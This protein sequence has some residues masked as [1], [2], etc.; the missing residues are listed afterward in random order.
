MH[1]GLAIADRDLPDDSGVA[2]A[3][4]VDAA[5][6][7]HS[8]WTNE[9]GGADATVAL[10]AWAAVTDRVLLA[11]GVIPLSARSTATLQL[12]TNRLSRLSHGRLLLGVGVGQRAAAEKL[13]ERPWQ[14]P[15]QWTRDAVGR[16]QGNGAP[17]L[18][19]ALGPR[20]LWLA[21]TA[22]DGAVL[23]WSTAAYARHQRAQFDEAAESAGS[24][25]STQLL[26][27]YVRVAAGPDAAAALAAQIAFYAKLPF[28]REHWATMGDPDD[29]A[30]TVASPDG[31]GLVDALAAYDAFDV[32]VARIVPTDA[33]G[34]ERMTELLCAQADERGA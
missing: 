7:V 32:V 10:G 23:N 3:R 26:C 29:A 28:Y 27:G 11:T 22:A 17:V 16:L 30:V 15:L 24:D 6:G 4:G 18:V 20:M 5:A 31:A 1:F 21:A 13:H 9:T 19:G 12:A 33:Y 25:R 34:V 14:P 2:L 8:L